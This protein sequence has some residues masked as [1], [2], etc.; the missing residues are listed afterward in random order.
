MYLGD[1]TLGENVDTD[2]TTVD[3]G[4]IPTQ[5]A[6]SPVISA[7]VGNSTTQITAGITLTVDFDSVTG[8]NH[9]RVVASSGNGYAVGTEVRLVITTGTVG[10]DS[11]VGYVIAAFSIERSNGVLARL[12]AS[13]SE[14]GQGTPAASTDVLTK[15]DY[16]FKNWRNKKTQTST[17]FKL[18]A[19]DATTVDQK[20]TV[21]DDGTTATIQEVTTGP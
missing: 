13:R 21:A 2:F 15:I 17:Q 11:V 5:L 7:Y 19:D 9:V 8:L 4:G 12:K 20:A 6:G 10:G 14:P 1:F 18:F 16:L 3:S